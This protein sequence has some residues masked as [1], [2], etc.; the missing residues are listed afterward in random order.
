MKNKLLSSRVRL[1]L[2]VAFLSCVIPASSYAYFAGGGSSN[3]TVPDSAP[4]VI[5]S[6]AYANTT[7]GNAVTI[8][9]HVQTSGERNIAIAE[10]DTG[11]VSGGDIYDELRPEDGS[12]VK[13][14]NSTADNLGALDTQVKQNTD[15]IGTLTDG[16]Y[17]SADKTIGE[18]LASLDSSILVH[19]DGEVT[20]IDPSGTSTKIDVSGANG[21]RVIT[22]VATDTSDRSSAA[23]VGY[24]DDTAAGLRRDMS[25]GFDGVYSSI[26]NLRGTVN[27]VAAGAAALAALDYLPYDPDN[28]LVFAAGSGTYRGKTAM[29]LGMKFQLRGKSIGFFPLVL[30]FS[31]GYG[32]FNRFFLYLLS[33]S[34]AEKWYPISPAGR[35]A[36]VS[37]ALPADSRA[38]GIRGDVPSGQ[39]QRF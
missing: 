23:N 36:D 12:Y 3:Y 17:I 20:T 37:T 28:K 33:I 24:V 19:T 25:S 7:L 13:E 15:T 27:E 16:T 32:E 38:C 4:V 34:S 5:G 39:P 22:G 14:S 18:N 6:G 11:L 30:C 29:A 26:S 35:A 8:G 1:S 21:D 31:S 2:S 9:A 10:G